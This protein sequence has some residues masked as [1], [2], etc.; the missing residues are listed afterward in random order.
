MQFQGDVNGTV[1]SYIREKPRDCEDFA[2]SQNIG[3]DFPGIA[4][5]LELGLKD[6]V[7]GGMA[8]RMSIFRMM[9]LRF[10]NNGEIEVSGPM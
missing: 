8:R 9:L 3:V 1:F 5:K 4:A 7:I 2:P 6:V 10:S